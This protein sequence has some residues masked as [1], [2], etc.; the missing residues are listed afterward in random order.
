[1]DVET[2]PRGMDAGEPRL[3]LS[4]HRALSDGL[5]G[6]VNTSDLRALGVVPSFT[7]R[8]GGGA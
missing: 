3:I 7:A 8:A 4:S 1:M 5:R 6:F 2:E